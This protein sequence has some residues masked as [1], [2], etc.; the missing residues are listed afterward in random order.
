LVEA[1]RVATAGQPTDDF[2]DRV[3]AILAEKRKAKSEDP[4]Q[5]AE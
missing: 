5:R 2:M 3:F 1:S 4:E